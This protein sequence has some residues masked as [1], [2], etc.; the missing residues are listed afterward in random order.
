MPSRTTSTFVCLMFSVAS[1]A[2]LAASAAAPAARK[3][4][5]I[6]APD[7]FPK[8]CVDCHVAKPAGLPSDARLSSALAKWTAGKVDAGLLAQAQGA[9]PAGL[10]L[11][12]KH[13]D[14][15]DSL[16]DIPVGCQDCHSDDSKK[17]PPLAR[18]VHRIHLTGGEQNAFMTV[19]QGECTHCHKLDA[20]TGAWSVPSG[21]EK[22]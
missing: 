19:Y 10:K 5:G 20:K 2:A 21:A 7:A 18:M 13:P 8:A 16:T 11:K 14:A 4:P 1:L 9:A 17:A 15:E 6:I 12:G 22:K 3:V